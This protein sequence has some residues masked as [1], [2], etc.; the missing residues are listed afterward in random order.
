M[1]PW[2]W[3]ILDTINEGVIIESASGQILMWNRGAEVIFGIS[4]REAIGRNLHNEGWEFIY[5]NGLKCDIETLP[6]SKTL[7]TG[8][9]LR[10]RKIGFHRTPEDIRWLSV[11][12]HPLFRNAAKSPYAV[13]ISFTDITDLK[14]E[15]DTSQNYL[16]IAEVMILALNSKG[17]VTLIN[18]KGCEILGGTE[19]DFIGKNWF[20]LFTPKEILD[21]VKKSFKEMM[22]GQIEITGYTE[23]RFHT[24]TRIEKVIAWHNTILKDK[25][26]IIIGTLSSGEDITE[27]YE[28]AERLR[29]S[30]RRH[31]TILRTAMDGFWLIDL[32]DRLLEVNDTY[33]RMSGYS[34]EELLQMDFTALEAIE[35]KKEILEKKDILL[36]AGERRFTTTHR[37]KDG[38]LFDVE[39]SAKYQPEEKRVVC[40]LRDITEQRQAAKRLRESEEKLLRS[41]KMESLGLL[42][43]GVAHDLNNVLTGI[44][45]YPE[46]LLMDLPEDSKYRK[47]VETIH[48]SGKRAA[49]IVQDL[50]TIARGVASPKEPIRPN[51][52]I[53]EYTSSPEFKKLMQ[54]HPEVIFT[55][56]LDINLMNISGSTIHIRKIIMNLV[57][58]AAEAIKGSGKVIVST[59][60][61]IIDN[62]DKD[63][64][65][66]KPGEYAVISVMDDGAGIEPAHMDRIFEPFFS[67]KVMGRSGTGLGLAVVW[68]IVQDHN[69]YIDVIS[70]EKGTTFEIY[71][72]VTKNDVAK[73]DG[74]V[75]IERLKG[76]GERVLVV[77][78]ED[79]PREIIVRMLEALN[80]RTEAV[81]SGEAAIEYLHKQQVD[82]VVLDM[83]MHPGI[84]G[85]KTYEEILKIN[86]K[87]KAIIVSGFAETDDV[88]EAQR[89]GAGRYIRKPFTI[90]NIGLAMKEIIN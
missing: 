82:I 42:A 61:R 17:E 44:V 43:G 55:E 38:S 63:Y 48:N 26:G 90:E 58:N 29:E 27:K 10:N 57:T 18:R 1:E 89:L 59:F 30:E 60:N 81:T 54:Y 64:N 22:A 70:D 49:A 41:K 21:E 75:S 20:D 4:S 68:N 76:N 78:D 23:Y 15:K 11:N 88:K 71:L 7:K 33:C 5:E 9:P 84:N 37:R 35:S 36:D 32:K 87:Q 45:S 14:I 47:P 83:I 74:P 66:I 56:D 24:L 8:I 67:K 62:N 85:R 80:Y 13:A 16:D 53:R 2:T 51:N 69:G 72:P 6:F 12:T 79:G 40:F 34:R 73:T 3:Q 46:I 19:E 65:D 28:A 31:R 77:D 86:P 25:D 39:I 52:I 50:I